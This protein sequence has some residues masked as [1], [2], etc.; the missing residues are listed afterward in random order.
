MKILNLYG[1]CSLI[2]CLLVCQ[3]NKVKLRRGLDSA[4][5]GDLCTLAAVPY[6]FCPGHLH[7]FS[8]AFPLWV[9]A[10]STG[11]GFSH[12]WGRS[13]EFCVTVTILAY[14]MTSLIGSDL[15]SSKH[16][17]GMS[18]PVTDCTVCV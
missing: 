3:I 10:M 12:H 11:N 5:I 8:L 18:F 7:P 4:M 13:G 14:C 6:Q 9:C 1:S 17:K 2:Q 15:A 16:Y